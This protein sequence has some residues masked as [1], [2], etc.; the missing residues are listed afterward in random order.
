MIIIDKKKVF[1]FFYN[2]CIKNVCVKSV[3]LVKG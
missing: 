1:Y 3:V 2:Y